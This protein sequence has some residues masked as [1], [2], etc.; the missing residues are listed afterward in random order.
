MSGVSF[1]TFSS[2]VILF[3]VKEKVDYRKRKILFSTKGD[4]IH[5]LYTAVDKIGKTIKI[6]ELL[7]KFAYE[8]SVHLE[9]EDVFVLTYNYDTNEFYT[10]SGE[11]VLIHPDTMD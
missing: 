4:Y 1:F 11:R 5:Q 6:D 10:N 9:L 7:E 2:L 8:V 3:Y